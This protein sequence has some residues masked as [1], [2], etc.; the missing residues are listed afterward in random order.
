[1]SAVTETQNVLAGLRRNEPV[2][3]KADED[4]QSRFL[5]LLTTQLRNQDPMN[6]MENAEVTSQLA[7]M[8][9]VDGI[10]RLNNMFRQFLDAQDSAEALQ[11]A[12]L[13]GRGVLVEG[14]GMILTDAGGIG[15]FELDAPAERVVLSIRD[16]AGLEVAAVEL[17]GLEAGSHNY[18]WDGTALDGTRAANGMYRV[19]VSATDGGESVSAK[20]LEF[21]TVS[22]VM[23]GSKSTDLQV[24]SLG[25]FR[26]DDIKQIL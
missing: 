1:M 15:G 3:K 14:N 18:V 7:Q 11:A 10:E 17:S 6:P 21:G 8:S 26:L 9:T 25:I 19:S 22:G 2:N 5:T 12:S 20:G 24:G 23:R 4:P 13:V 16:V